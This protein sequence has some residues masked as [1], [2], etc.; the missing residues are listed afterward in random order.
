MQ[1]FIGGFAPARPEVGPSVATSEAQAGLR[2][3]K[4]RH[5]IQAFHGTGKALVCLWGTYPP[6]NGVLGSQ[7]AQLPQAKKNP[8]N[9][10]V[11]RVSGG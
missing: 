1:P 2:D 9:I 10:G 6:K 4:Q 11:S 7:W 5:E 3:K 8:E